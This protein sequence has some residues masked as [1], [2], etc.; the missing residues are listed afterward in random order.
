MNCRG[1]LSWLQNVVDRLGPENMRQ[2]RCSCFGHL[3]DI[4]KLENQGQ[5]YNVMLRK[6]DASSHRRL[7]L[8]FRIGTNLL[9]FGP[10]QFCSVT[11]LKFSGPPNLP[12]SSTFH[13][14]IF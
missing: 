4:S 8:S 14:T 5:L 9:E 1:H 11:G 13:K 3:F 12:E 6:L 10:E 2:M 7:S